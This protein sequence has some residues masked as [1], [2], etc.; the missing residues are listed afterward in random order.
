MDAERKSEGVRVLGIDYAFL[1]HEEEEAKNPIV[2]MKCHQTRYTFSHVV[3]AKGSEA[4]QSLIVERLIDDIAV[5]GYKTVAI[6]CD[7]EGSIRDLRN[8]MI[9]KRLEDTQMRDAPKGDSK[10]QGSIERGIQSV[11]GQIRAIKMGVERRIG[12]RVGPEWPLMHWIVELAGFHISHYEKGQD[13]LT[14]YRRLTGRD[15]DVP[16]V[17]MAECV[18]F[19]PLKS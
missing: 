5:L 3:E 15:W 7:R 4:G 10:A 17:E 13:G 16:V 1:D 19:K 2:V 12:R 18:M 11:E 8:A 9:R 6:Q 14:P